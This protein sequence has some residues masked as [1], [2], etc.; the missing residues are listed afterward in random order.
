[1]DLYY[2]FLWIRMDFYYSSAALIIFNSNLYPQLAFFLLHK[3]AHKHRQTSRC[4]MRSLR[5][6]STDEAGIGSSENL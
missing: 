2:Y 3:K 1:M 6:W 4:L 5:C